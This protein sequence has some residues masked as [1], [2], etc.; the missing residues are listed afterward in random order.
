MNFCKHHQLD[1][2]Y[3]LFLPPATGHRPSATGH[4]PPATGH[5]P[6]ATGHRPPATGHRPPTTGHHRAADTTS[7]TGHRPPTTGHHRAANTTGLELLTS[8]LLVGFASLGSKYRH[9]HGGGVRGKPGLFLSDD[10]LFYRTM[11]ICYVM[12]LIEAYFITM[13]FFAL[14]QTIM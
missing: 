6:P 14:H 13:L 8:G 12:F 10:D 7:H 3:S 1:G 2:H 9:L 4:R 11:W 5:R